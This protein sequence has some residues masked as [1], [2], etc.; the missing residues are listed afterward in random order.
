[1]VSPAGP[2]DPSLPGRKAAGGPIAGGPI[3]GGPIAGGWVA[4][5]WVAGSGAD[6]PA[7]AASDGG[8]RRTWFLVD[9]DAFFVSVEQRRDAALKGRCVA[10][11]GAPGT[12]GVVC[13]AS[14]EA[15]RFGVTSAMPSSR[16]ASLCP[17][18]VFVPPDFPA[19]EAASAE[20]FEV[21]RAFAPRVEPVSLDE[22]YLE[23]TGCERVHARKGVPRPWLDV[24][25]DLRAAVLDR[26][27]LSVS[28]GVGGTR[29][30]A[31]VAAGL[32]KPAGIL[33]VPAGAEAA[34]L[35]GLAVEA[36][37]GVGET[38]RAALARLGIVRIGDLARAPDDV[39]EHALGRHGMRLA[40]HARGE[41]DGADD[42]A[43]PATRSISRETSF[44]RDVADL[45]RLAGVLSDLAQ[46]ACRA[47]RAAG[48]LARSVGV[49]LRDAAFCT[50]EARRRLPEPTDRDRDVLVA[51][52]ALLRRRHDGR[53]PI[54]LVGVVLHGLVPASARTPGLFDELETGSGGPAAGRLDAALDALRA[55]H[56]F[57]AVVRGRAIEGGLASGPRAPRPPSRDARPERPGP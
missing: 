51:A 53:T 11:G 18:L 23:V 5:G 57:G 42:D 52:D 17:G 49:K 45:D 4:G 10:V 30:V 54:R 29:T 40:R 14:Y 15:R 46:H 27:A 38:T 25:G 19:Y 55:R 34:F 1:M 43:A 35:A 13:S 32:A 21:F 56:G 33:E 50:T 16:A 39:L 44:E 24:A 20:V 7:G 8:G 28:V 6:A 2:P 37:P 47:L 12:R 31:K 36:L 3:A 22:A 9:L 48:L 26:T 41:P